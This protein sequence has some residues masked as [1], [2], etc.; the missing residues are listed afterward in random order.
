M[1]RNRIGRL[2]AAIL[3][4]T[5]LAAATTAVSAGPAAAGTQTGAGTVYCRYDDRETPPTISYGAQG[6]TVKEAQCLLQFKGFDI[7][8]SGVDGD[9]GSSTRSAV[10]TAQAEYGLAVDGIVGPKT[11][12]WLRF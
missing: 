1:N 11:W 8:S 9:F 6:D 3:V 4:T 12:Y 2:T 7:G 5:A 10:R